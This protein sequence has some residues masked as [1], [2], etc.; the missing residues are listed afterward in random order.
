MKSQNCKFEVFFKNDKGF[1]LRLLE[2]LKKGRFITEFPEASS[3]YEDLSDITDQWLTQGLWNVVQDK[4]TIQDTKQLG[5]IMSKYISHSNEANCVVQKWQVGELIMTGLYAKRDIEQN[6]ELFLDYTVPYTGHGIIDPKPDPLI[7]TDKNFSDN[8]GKPIENA[9]DVINF[10]IDLFRCTHRFDMAPQIT[11]DIIIL[12]F[13]I[14]A[15]GLD[16]LRDLLK[17]DPPNLVTIKKILEILKKL[18]CDRKYLKFYNDSKIKETL[19]KLAPKI[20]QFNDL[21]QHLLKKWT[22]I[23]PKTTPRKPTPIPLPPLPPVPSPFSV[24]SPYTATIKYAPRFE[25]YYKPRNYYAPHKPS[26]SYTTSTTTINDPQRIAKEDKG[27]APAYVGPSSNG[28]K[29]KS[30][31]SSSLS[32]AKYESYPKQRKQ[33]TPIKSSQPTII[34]DIQSITKIENEKSSS[35]LKSKSSLSSSARYEPYAIPKKPVT[36]KSSQESAAGPTIAPKINDDTLKDK[37]QGEI[38]AAVYQCSLEFK[39]G[40]DDRT[41]EEHVTKLG[42]L[43]FQKESKIPKSTGQNSYEFTDKVRNRIKD[44]V[45]IY[46]KKLVAKVQASKIEQEKTTD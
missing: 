23:E 18:P 6:E 5:G 17:G 27:K 28:L 20:V 36:P 4:T 41:F 7:A 32:S 19:I 42:G 14:E 24:S 33:N 2:P 44:F 9:D 21:F 15:L 39:N 46:M 8:L 25:P 29:S 1:G 11:N 35:S 12:G 37:L 3:S 34:K 10:R 26:Q 31:L 13:F 16:V 43:C 30:S 38:N 40:L 45:K 22:E